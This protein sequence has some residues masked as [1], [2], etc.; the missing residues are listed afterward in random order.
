[1]PSGGR[2]YWPKSDVRYDVLLHAKY[3]DATECLIC[4]FSRR[5]ANGKLWKTFSYVSILHRIALLYADNVSFER[6]MT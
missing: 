6:M 4:G 3:A 1:M 2:K 5:D